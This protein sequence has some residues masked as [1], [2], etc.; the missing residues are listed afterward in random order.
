MSVRER[1]PTSGST[2]C[3]SD[4]YDRHLINFDVGLRN[5]TDIVYYECRSDSPD[6]HLRK[7]MSVRQI[8]PTSQLRDVGRTGQHRHRS[9]IMSV[10]ECQTDI[11]S[12]PDVGPMHKTDIAIKRCRS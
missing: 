6:R 7:W 9:Q 11:T 2:R 12:K 8:E 3:R 5:R 4:N 10:R 1:A